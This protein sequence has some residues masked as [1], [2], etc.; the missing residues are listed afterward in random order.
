LHFGILHEWWWKVFDE[1]SRD[2]DSLGSQFIQK[3]VDNSV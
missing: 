1:V 3:Y 2:L